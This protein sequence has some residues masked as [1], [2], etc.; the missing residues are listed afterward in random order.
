VKLLLYRFY[1]LESRAD[2]ASV[3][4][5]TN[6]NTSTTVLNIIYNFSEMNVVYK[7][8]LLKLSGA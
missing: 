6:E 8:L 4:K 3:E 5:S 7:F 2:L 1:T